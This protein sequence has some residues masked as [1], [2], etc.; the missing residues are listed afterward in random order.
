MPAAFAV[1]PAAW[2]R[3]DPHGCDWATDYHHAL[4]L[5]SLWECDCTIWKA[6]VKGSAYRFGSFIANP[7]PA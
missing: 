7:V 6:P 2:N 1:Q 5:A 4:K 3:F